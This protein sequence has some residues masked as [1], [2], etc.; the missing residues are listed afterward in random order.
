MASGSVTD[1]TS[2]VMVPQA[3]TTAGWK[4]AEDAL[5]PTAA[6]SVNSRGN[7]PCINSAMRFTASRA[8]KM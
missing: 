1:R 2:A 8:R 7:S 6:S 3:A 4:K 5:P